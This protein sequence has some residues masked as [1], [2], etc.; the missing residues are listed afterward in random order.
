MAYEEYEQT[1]DEKIASLVQAG[2][3]DLFGILVKR[4][5]E[6]IKRYASKVL[7]NRDDIQ[8]VVQDI[9]VKSYI[10]IKSFD[11]KRRFSPWIYR[12][13]HNEIVN[14]F[15]RNKLR[16]FLPI[17][18]PDIFLPQALK[19]DSSINKAVER[20]EMKSII[21][22]YIGDLGNKYK[23]PIVLYYIEELNYQ[24]IAEILHLPVATVG[25]RIRRGK[26]MLK[27][28]FTKKGFS[29]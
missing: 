18:E 23:E 8:D 10:N 16:T 1:S 24:E 28:I 11:T 27:T 22:K 2:S 14:L 4:Y 26:E 21:D 13:A 15:K 17:L 7:S 20:N 25:T 9:F 29:Y 6:K 19:D 5:E 12:I 3:G